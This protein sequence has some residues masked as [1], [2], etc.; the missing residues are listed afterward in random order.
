MNFSSSLMSGMG[1]SLGGLEI[2][3]DFLYANPEFY[4]PDLT[5]VKTNIYGKKTSTVVLERPVKPVKS[6]ESII[7]KFNILQTKQTLGK[8]FIIEDTS[9]V[10]NDD[11]FDFSFEDDIENTPD[12]TS[13]IDE[14]SEAI[15]QANMLM[16]AMQNNIDNIQ[17]ED[18]ESLEDQLDNL[19]GDE[20]YNDTEEISED[21]LEDTLEDQLDNLFGDEDE[22]DEDEDNVIDLESQLE[23]LFEEDIEDEDIQ[24][25][26]EDISQ[27]IEDQLDNIF[28]DEED[29]ENI[30]NIEVE[31]IENNIIQK[32][33]VEPSVN[34]VDN[35]EKVIDNEQQK[36][37]EQMR[38][39]MANM[40][41]QIQA[42][43]KDKA[44]NKSLND[45]KN[46]N[47]DF[48]D[49]AISNIEASNKKGE[50]FNNYDKYT[51]MSIETLYNTVKH[52]M[53]SHGV[54]SKPIEYTMLT[55][56]FGEINIKK[57][58]QKSYLI[59]IGKGVT[60]GR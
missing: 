33:E 40:E 21:L 37:I 34:E 26:V 24:E 15:M 30:Q 14:D 46:M 44:H 53:I 10:K 2:A 18:E 25:E 54:G 52:Y 3:T 16:Q 9:V 22:E 42:M 12:T 38:K 39:R 11:D 4:E 5:E 20:E 31:H 29:Y 58:V 8:D 43:T 19:F 48:I 32:E 13:D 35:T 57:L 36:T 49:N 7:S 41:K 59:K 47:N 1:I 60:V 55:K 23:N 28:D 50:S 27:S 45:N 56:E 6:R 51:V 17:D